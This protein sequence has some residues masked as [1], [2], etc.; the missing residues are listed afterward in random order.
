MFGSVSVRLRLVYVPVVSFATFNM[1]EN[2]MGRAKSTVTGALIAA[3]GVPPFCGVRVAAVTVTLKETTSQT[4]ESWPKTTTLALP[5]AGELLLPEGLEIV[6]E[7]GDVVLGICE[8]LPPE[9]AM[10]TPV[11]GKRPATATPRSRAR[12]RSLL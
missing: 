10:K 11:A 2:S 1:S 12:M 6:F 5:G 3:T 8:E 4:G 9:K 7:L